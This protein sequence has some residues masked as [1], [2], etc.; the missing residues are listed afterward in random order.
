MRK[1]GLLSLPFLFFLLALVATGFAQQK[2]IRKIVVFGNERVSKEIILNEI[3][4]KVGGPFSKDV[5]REDVKA[6]YRL[7]YFRDVQVDM[8]ETEEGVILTFA[9]IEKPFVE[10]VVISG[11][12][13]VDRKDIDEVI[14]V[15]RDA[16]LD[17]GKVGSSVKALKKL[18]TSK[19]Y[20]GS[21]IEH[22]VEHVKGNKA[23]VY[24]DITE[25]V[26]GF[27]KKIKFVGN[28]AFG[29]R[30]LRGVMRTKK[31]GWFWWLTKSGT[32]EMDALEMDINRIK[33]FYHDH[34]YMTVKVSDPE[35]TLSKDKKSILI[36]I[37]IE[38]GDRFKLGSLDIMGDILTTKEE[39]LKGLSS[40]VGKVYRSSLVHKDLLWLTDRYADEGYA[41][42]DVVPLTRL[43]QE[44]KLV[45]LVFKIEKGVKVYINRIEIKGNIKTRDKVI[46]RELKLAERDLYSSALL[47]KSRER[48][49][50]TGY[51]KEVDFAASPTEKKELIDLDIRVEEAEAGAL[52]FGTGYS[53]LYGVTGTVSISHKNLFGLGYRAYAKTTI[54]QEI[55]EYS[56]GLMDPRI[57]DSQFSAGFDAYNETYERDTYDARVTGGDLKIGREITDKIRA[58]L[59]YLY[60][61]VKIFDVHEGA[62]DYIKSQ[63]GTT[64]TG[65]AT[66]TIT[67]DTIDNIFSPRRGSKIWISGTIAGLGGDNFFYKARTGASWFH[68][69]IGDLILNL[70]GDFGIA[71]GYNGKEVP[72]MEKF[73]VGGIRT[74]R[75]F[76]Y[77][78]AGPLDEKNEPIGALNKLT[79]T[80]ELTYPLS[81]AIGLRVAVFYDVGKGFDDFD[82]V[83]PLRHAVGVGIRWY[84]PFGPIRIDWGYNLDPKP[85][86]GEKTNVWEF[87]AGVVY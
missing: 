1:R 55:Q 64:T 87:S 50:R 56:V 3:K 13:K 82:E 54:G 77:G 27:V 9:V 31:K 45:H 43:D 69:I 10:D 86:R 38:E 75:G 73:Y 29:A 32:L 70:K 53:S 44:R 84:S 23:V 30:K 8:S 14:E 34:G 57:L 28:K 83:T 36:T 62:S 63:E 26:K 11:N 17:M 41:Y 71:R 6:I 85:E 49:K 16:V 25:G 76:E 33:S 40:R 2:L 19:G 20:Y 52:Q 5:I 68:P 21:E 66:L 35:I 48:L 65:K 72:L 4:S 51:F 74:L 47:R 81:K 7:G 12:R 79:F 78:M 22:R 46:R 61:R 60:E 59:I 24:F 15:K 58:D 18:Y 37:E 42:V 39:L 80:T 67:R